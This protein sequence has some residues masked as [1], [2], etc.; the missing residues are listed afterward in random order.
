VRLLYKPDLEE[1]R[2]HWQAFWAGEIIDRPCARIVAPSD[3]AAPVSPP[4]SLQ[5]PDSDLDEV[6]QAQDRYLA[7]LYFG[8][9]AIPFFMPNFGPDVYAAFL[10]AHLD[11]FSAADGTSWAVPFVQD[12]KQAVDTLSRPHG[13]WW[14]SA[15][16]FTA[17]ARQPATGKFVIAM[18]DL[19]SN[20]DCLAAV[21]GPQ[22]LCMDLIDCPD[23]VEAALNVVRSTYRP[24]YDALYQA[25]GQADTGSTSWLPM[26]SE[27]K[28][29]VIQCDF[30][31]MISPE[32]VRR[33][34]LPALEEEAE[35]LD[36]CCFHLDGPDALVHLDDILSIK[37]IDAV[38]WVPGAGAKRFVE[39]IDLLKK[40]QD[41]GKALHAPVTPD[42]MK[43]LHKELRPEKV[44]YDVAARS[45]SEADALLDWLTAN[46]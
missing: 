28:F 29:N 13:Y 41:A 37:A 2:K 25:S 17:R 14:E 42:E 10:G 7:S 46:T 30:I 9:D 1:A 27:G 32:A 8:G 40:I 15:L 5:H 4:S 26:Y 16:D 33:F 38:Q 31:C 3:P 39:W 21:R 22:N 34:V 24:I 44:F 12:W 23:E 35:F 19:H 11:G 6:L 43:M 18:W 45:R 36:H 20:M